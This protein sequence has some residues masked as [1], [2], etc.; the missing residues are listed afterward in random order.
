[1][2]RD[3]VGVSAKGSDVIFHPFER[4][5]LVPHSGIVMG[6]CCRFGKSEYT[7]PVVHAYMDH[8]QPVVDGFD[9]Q[10][11]GLGS[12]FVLGSN[13]ETSTY[14]QVSGFPLF[15]SSLTR[16]VDENHNR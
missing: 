12:Q 11:T 4:E 7:Q 5:P 6:Q 16:T 3:I 13:N 10:A 9:D 1:M 2:D 15:K 8:R 14:I